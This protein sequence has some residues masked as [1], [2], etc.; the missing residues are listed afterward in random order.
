MATPAPFDSRPPRKALAHHPAKSRRCAERNKCESRRGGAQSTL[1]RRGLLP[2]RALGGPDLLQPALSGATSEPT[3]P[4]AAAASSPSGASSRARNFFY[5]AAMLGAGSA[6]GNP[7]PS[8]SPSPANPG[9]PA[10]TPGSTAMPSHHCGNACHS[11]DHL[12]P[13]GSTFSER[14]RPRTF[15][16]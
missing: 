13:G 12:L 11:D 10:T 7:C 2:L 6:P 1:R 5:R 14:R 3:R 8:G 9:S 4:L 16:V 15:I